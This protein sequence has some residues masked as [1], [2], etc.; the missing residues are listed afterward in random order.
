MKTFTPEFEIIDNAIICN[1][2][3]QYELMYSMARFQE[4]YENP[5]LKYSLFERMDLQ[6]IQPDY[7]VNWNGCNFPPII[8]D[9]MNRV[10]FIYDRHELVIHDFC[11][12]QNKYIIGVHSNKKNLDHELAH[13]K[14]YS[15]S[16]YRGHVCN[17]I[18]RINENK[19]KLLREKLLSMGY[20]KSVIYDE[21]QAYSRSGWEK[22]GFDWTI[23]FD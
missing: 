17:T 11:H 20:D 21:I 14:Y 23:N 15:D 19:I 4:F 13:A 9:E 10:G 12:R 7:Y 18:D 1:Y 6:D 8:F 5:Y 16:I 2:K 3:S 22:L